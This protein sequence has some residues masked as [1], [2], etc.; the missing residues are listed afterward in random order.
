MSEP[1]PNLDEAA[2]LHNEAMASCELAFD[3]RR[4]GDPELALRYFSEAFAAEQEAANLVADDLDLEPTR[5][6]LH[7]SAATLAA[8]CGDY[9][10]ANRLIDA[11]L[12]GNPP[13]E[14]IEELDELR[15]RIRREVGPGFEGMSIL[16]DPGNAPVE[17][18]TEL[19]L[20]LDAV[21]RSLGGPGLIGDPT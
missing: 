9:P 17:L 2:R 20:S 14:I 21:N 8:D 16:I 10:A 13:V 5:S 18:I 4:S 15:V 12:A 7:R 3:A 6:I 19:F 11:A 1:R